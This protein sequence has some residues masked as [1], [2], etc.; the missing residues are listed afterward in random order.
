MPPGGEPLTAGD[1]DGQDVLDP[2][3]VLLPLIVQGPAR[4]QFDDAGLAA[5]LPRPGGGAERLEREAAVARTVGSVA[6]TAQGGSNV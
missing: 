3:A 6:M 5:Q 4:A 1:V 2:A